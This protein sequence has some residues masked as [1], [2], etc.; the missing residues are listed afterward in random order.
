MRGSQ[1]YWLRLP[2]EY[3]G[4]GLANPAGV[5]SKGAPTS[6]G[7][8]ASLVGTASVPRG[9]GP[10]AVPTVLRDAAR[11]SERMARPNGTQSAADLV[12]VGG[13]LTSTADGADDG[14][15]PNIVTVFRDQQ[16]EN[17]VS[18]RTGAP[19]PQFA[20]ARLFMLALVG[21]TIFLVLRR[22]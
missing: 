15:D 21:V 16:P 3:V 5:G 14:N 12:T 11:D 4:E 9:V 1:Y 2:G 8:Q 18:G 17:R 19:P 7:N 13:I 10:D 20:Q 6:A 22:K